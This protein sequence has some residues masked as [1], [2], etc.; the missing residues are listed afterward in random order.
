MVRN[1]QG[2]HLNY[3][4]A[5]LQ[6][7]NL[8]QEM[9]QFAEDEIERCHIHVA[10]VKTVEN[11]YDFQL[12][13]NKFTRNLGKKMQEKFGGKTLTT[14]KLYGQKDGKEIFRVTVLFRGVPF[15]RQ[16]IVI[17]KAEEHTVTAMGKEIIL[18]H[19][20]SGKKIHLNYKN[21]D[22]IKPKKE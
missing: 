9:L 12:A 8:T 4:E 18:Q 11:G 19:N 13:D 17:Y 15:Q 14:A 1:I 2:K 5:N 7:R 3:F 16:D 22:S 20:K 10:K 6:L 21:M